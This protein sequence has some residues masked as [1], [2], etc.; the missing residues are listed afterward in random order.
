MNEKV[1][2]PVPAMPVLNTDRALQGPL[3]K[4]VDRQWTLEEEPI[5]PDEK[6]LVLAIKKAAQH[7]ENGRVVEEVVEPNELPDIKAK[8]EDI[9]EE[10]WEL[11]ADGITR[12]APWSIA[13][14]VYLL[15]LRDALLCTSINKTGGQ[16]AAANSL[17][18]RIE[19][20][21]ALKHE[22]M[23]PVVTLGSKLHSRQFKKYRPDFIILDGEWRRFGGGPVEPPRL[24]KP[25]GSIGEKVEPPS[26]KDELDDEIGF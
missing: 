26:L 16:H 6:F 10:T 13:A 3:A 22:T 5:S 21:S 9:P 7:W 8:N 15:R 2:L 25:S 20:M 11:G 24:E 12:Q 23:W 14:A 19:W 18:S 4:F 17:R 1:N